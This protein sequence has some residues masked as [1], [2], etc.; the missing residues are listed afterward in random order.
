MRLGRIYELLL[1]GAIAFGG[2]CYVMT[3]RGEADTKWASSSQMI[4]GQFLQEGNVRPLSPSAARVALT[5]LSMDA[6]PI[7]RNAFASLTSAPT[8]Q[9]D[10]GTAG[11]LQVAILNSDS[12]DIAY[13]LFAADG[14][15]NSAVVFDRGPREATV[16][17]NYQRP[18][19]TVGHGDQLDVSFTPRAAVSL[20]PDGS[21]AGAGAEV[22]VG[23]YLAE[24]LAD[25]PSWYMFAGA[26]RRALLYD[27][28]QGTDFTQA[29]SLTHR[30]V[31]GDLQAGVAMRMGETDLSVAYV[32]REYKHVAGVTSFDETESF[33][34][35]SLNWT[36]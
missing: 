23:R 34:A 21:A 36:W 7:G 16:A 1:A 29:V 13:D 20:G 18:F 14:N 11:M 12:N 22:R 5:A 19:E 6:D 31:I 24:S 30:E 32:R 15:S 28:A 2:T 35:V 26:D 10:L 25:R 27:P 9:I 33:G 3:T 8:A 17:V 4:Q